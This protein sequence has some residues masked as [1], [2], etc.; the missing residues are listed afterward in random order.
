MP[1]NIKSIA[2][3]ARSYTNHLSNAGGTTNHSTRLPNSSSQVHPQGVRRGCKGLKPQ[4]HMQAGY[5]DEQITSI[6]CAQF[7]AKRIIVW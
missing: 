6:H 7:G 5:Q 1:A 3:M 4:Q 2:G